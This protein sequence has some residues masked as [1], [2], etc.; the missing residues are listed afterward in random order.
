MTT[1]IKKSFFKKKSLTVNYCRISL[2]DAVKVQRNVGDEQEMLFSEFSVHNFQQFSHIYF[3]F[4][5]TPDLPGGIN[6]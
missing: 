2:L 5:G 3:S 4:C 6:G 1:M